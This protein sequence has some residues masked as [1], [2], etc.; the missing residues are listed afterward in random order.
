MFSNS[1]YLNELFSSKTILTKS[2]T[3]M[4][5]L[6]FIDSSVQD[7]N[8]LLTNLHSN[9]EAYILEPDRNGVE[10]ITQKIQSLQIEGL[11]SFASLFLVTHGSP[12]SL[13][14]GNTELS[15]STLDINSKAL[16]KWF[17]SSPKAEFHLYLS[18]IHISEPTRPY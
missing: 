14:L 18:L 4:K 7:I 10:Q 6:L 11:T 15:L 16:K 8:L 12:G 13:R 3:T 1:D 5:S 2:R 9:I 17:S